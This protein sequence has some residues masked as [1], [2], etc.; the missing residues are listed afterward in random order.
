MVHSFNRTNTLLM[1][2]S[3]TFLILHVATLPHALAQQLDEF[4][5]Y[6]AASA[7]GLTAE[8]RRTLGRLEGNRYLLRNKIEAKALGSTLAELDERSEFQWLDSSAIP[9]RWTFEQSGLGSGHESAE[10]DWQNEFLLSIEDDESYRLPLREGVTDKLTYQLQLRQ[11]LLTTDQ[12]EFQFWVVDQDEI[13]LHLYRKVADEVLST[14]LGRLNTVR[15]ERVRDTEDSRSTIIWLA[16][17]WQYL[18]VGLEQTDRRGRTVE[19]MAN[20]AS[21]NGVAVTA[22]P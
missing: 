8:A 4:A 21:I 19:L 12:K 3:L 18:L 16:S 10:F 2:R 15:I 1:V 13:E 11:L 17:D 14:P 9:T 5:I 7:Y 6:Y 20:R 22:L